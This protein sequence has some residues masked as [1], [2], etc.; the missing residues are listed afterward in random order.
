VRTSLLM[1]AGAFI[2]LLAALLLWV[3]GFR[4]LA[5]FMFVVAGAIAVY[6]VVQWRRGT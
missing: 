6:A 2:D 1:G 4:A 3:V 5:I